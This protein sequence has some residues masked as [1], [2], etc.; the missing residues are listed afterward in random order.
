[1]RLSVFW[2]DPIIQ[3]FRLS[4]FY[5]CF[6][7]GGH[8]Y[9]LLC[10]LCLCYCFVYLSLG[11]ACL[12][13]L[14]SY[15]LSLCRLFCFYSVLPSSIFISTSILCL[16]VGLCG[17]SSVVL[18]LVLVLLSLDL[19]FWSFSSY[20]SRSSLSLILSSGYLCLS[21]VR[22]VSSHGFICL[23]LIYTL[24]FRSLLVF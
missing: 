11:L 22:L 17:L 3:G 16:E 8:G 24:S 14:R 2:V 15:F 4:C 12:F 18:L 13:V 7:L 5:C 6:V 1:M 9:S 21:Y 23:C 19:S 10:L 20:F